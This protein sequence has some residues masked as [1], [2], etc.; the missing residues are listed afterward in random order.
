MLLHRYAGL[1][2]PVI[3]VQGCVAV[4]LLLQTVTCVLKKS[5][6]SPTNVL[7]SAQHS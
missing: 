6:Y 4:E 2:T 7:P 5:N 1:G 3:L